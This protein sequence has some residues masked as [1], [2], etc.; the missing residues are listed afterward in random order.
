MDDVPVLLTSSPYYN[1]LREYWLGC[2]DR[3]IS[4]QKMICDA[5]ATWR[6]LHPIERLM[7]EESNYI[8][9][10]LAV[11]LLLPVTTKYKK[12]S[13]QA[14]SKLKATKPQPSTVRKFKST[15]PSKRQSVQSKKSK[16]NKCRS[17]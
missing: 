7:F 10:R 12:T 17:T 2:D 15:H 11:D 3:S 8:G 5:A 4:P 14:K 6:N 13:K 16:Q 9:A 1:F